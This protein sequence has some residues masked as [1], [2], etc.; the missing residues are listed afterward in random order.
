VLAALAPQA[1]EAPL[2]PLADASTLADFA[3]AFVPVTAIDE[4]RLAAPV[5]VAAAWSQL[6]FNA[7][8]KLMETAAGALDSV[9]GVPQLPSL[10]SALVAAAA[11]AVGSGYEIPAAILAALLLAAPRLGRRLRPTPDLRRPPFRLALI[12]N[13]G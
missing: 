10:P 8:V 9:P 1:A 6:A 3:G 11:S 7:G 4:G 13:P 12:E 2:T 5:F